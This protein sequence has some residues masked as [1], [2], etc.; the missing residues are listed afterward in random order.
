MY[1]CPLCGMDHDGYL[2]L[3]KELSDA[4]EAYGFDAISLKPEFYNRENLT[5]PVCGG[6]DRERMCAE[7]LRRTFGKNFYDRSFRFLEFAPN[8]AFSR[9][10]RKNFTL[11]HETADLLRSD[12]TYQCDLTNMPVLKTESVNA[13]I[14]LH[15]LEHIPDD[16]AALRELY[17]ILTPGGFGLLLVPLSLALEKT[18]EDPSASEFER[19]RRFGQNDHIRMYAKKDFIERILEAGFQLEQLGKEWFGE[20]CFARLG[21][22]DT[23]VLY[24]LKKPGLETS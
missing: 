11:R 20:K 8:P 12:V 1:Y 21:L 10:I 5:C 15:M 14:S 22:P 6:M 13:W 18:D 4:L 23:A 16:R 24:V 9:F 3:W 19:W 17:R 7:Y 2:P